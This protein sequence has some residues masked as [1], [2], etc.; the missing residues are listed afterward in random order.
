[1]LGLAYA[2]RYPERATETV[3]LSCTMPRP[4]DVRWLWDEAA[5]SFPRS[6]GSVTGG[7]GNSGDLIACACRKPRPGHETRRYSLIG[8][9]MGSLPSD[10]VLVKVGRLG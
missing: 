3:L 2:Q 4:A 1:M 7:G 8:P 6:S 9:P 5:R 10:A